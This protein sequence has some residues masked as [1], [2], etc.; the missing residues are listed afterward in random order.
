MRLTAHGLSREGI[1]ESVSGSGPT[2]YYPMTPNDEYVAD[3]W[4]NRF[5]DVSDLGV[6]SLRVQCK[7]PRVDDQVGVTIVSPPIEFEVVEPSEDFMDRLRAIS[8]GK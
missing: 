8:R 1:A 5:Y 2:K 3:L 7:M 6:Y 4:L